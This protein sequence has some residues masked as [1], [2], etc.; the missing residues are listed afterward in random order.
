MEPIVL[1]ITLVIEVALLFALPAPTD[2]QLRDRERARRLA[3]QITERAAR[4]AATIRQKAA[5]RAAE[6]RAR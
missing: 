6:L 1:L 3:A 5:R 4:R 2:R